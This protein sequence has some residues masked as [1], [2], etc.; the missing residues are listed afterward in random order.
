MASSF[1]LLHI[2]FCGT[3]NKNDEDGDENEDDFLLVIFQI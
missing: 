1:T 2:R 3:Q